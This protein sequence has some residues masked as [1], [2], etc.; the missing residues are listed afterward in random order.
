MAWAK[1]TSTTAAPGDSS[2]SPSR[3]GRIRAEGPPL[4]SLIYLPPTIPP[5]PQSQEFTP[6]PVPTA[7]PCPQVVDGEKLGL[8]GLATFGYSLSGRMDVDE[9]FYPDLL[10]GSLSDRIVLLR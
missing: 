1:C 3:Y 9:N 8:P 7:S 5:W 6:E 10:V 4:L 2:D